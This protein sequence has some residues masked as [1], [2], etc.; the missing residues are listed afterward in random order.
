VVFE[1]PA[2]TDSAV[3]GLQ[4]GSIALIWSKAPLRKCAC[5]CLWNNQIPR[6]FNQ[7]RSA[8]GE[9]IASTKPNGQ[10]PW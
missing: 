3:P 1:S 2:L 9:Q 4:P 7:R 6:A 10:S 5:W 8:T